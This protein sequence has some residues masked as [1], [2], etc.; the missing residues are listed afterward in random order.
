MM[1]SRQ[2]LS[3]PDGIA[4]RQIRVAGFLS[5]HQEHLRGGLIQ[6]TGRRPAH[7]RLHPVFVEQGME[8]NSELIALLY[9]TFK[10]ETKTP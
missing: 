6:I 5:V 4:R 2:T 3:L 1:P 8:R 10:R 9:Q 7:Y